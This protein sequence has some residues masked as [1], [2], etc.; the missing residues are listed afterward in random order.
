[1]VSIFPLPINTRFKGEINAVSQGHGPLVILFF[2]VVHNSVDSGTGYNSINVHCYG[3][4]PTICSQ[5]QF[6]ECK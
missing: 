4:N 5:Y 1:M 2:R 3:S 6:D